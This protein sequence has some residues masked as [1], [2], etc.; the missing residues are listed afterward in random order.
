MTSE[1]KSTLYPLIWR[2]RRLFQTLRA[3]S[4][5]LL[6]G[7]GINSS[8][9]AVLEFMFQAP[10]QTVSQIAREKS[11]SRQ[12]IQTVVNDLLALGL[13]ITA[14]N[15]SHKRSPL[16]RLTAEGKS[17]FL[18]IRKQE[19]RFLKKV[20]AELSERD[21]RKA[22]ATLQSV[23]DSLSTRLPTEAGVRARR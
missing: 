19:T 6:E 13:V 2:V 22:A 15:P 4:E 5:A 18:S 10:A 14:N 23:E 9:R 12:H 16:I 8:Q 3:T 7:Y 20:E 1:S 17:L 21:L 11:V